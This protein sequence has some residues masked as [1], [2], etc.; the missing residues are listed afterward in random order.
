M[1]TDA[2][3]REKCHIYFN[4]YRFSY[5]NPRIPC[6]FMPRDA[7]DAL[8]AEITRTKASRVRPEEAAV[9]IPM[10]EPKKEERTN[11]V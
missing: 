11:A 5:T 4:T 8:W 6:G 3:T 9:E 2:A 1:N 10:P 7:R